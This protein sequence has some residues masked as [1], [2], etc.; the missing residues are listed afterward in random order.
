MASEAEIIIAFLFKRSGKSELSF[1]EMYLTLS[2]DMNWF[3]PDGAKDFIKDSVKN[4]LLIQKNDY[5]RPGFKADKINVPLGFRPAGELFKK[6]DK[7]RIVE[8]DVLE[9]VVNEI[10]EKAE[11]DK[12]EVLKKI[13][14]I[15]EEKNIMPEVAALIIGKEFEVFS[16]EVFKKIEKQILE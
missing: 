4:K 9:E 6:D 13:K 3:T 16:E 7:E 2:M 11:I 14:K 10:V 12:S 8:K 5:L 1:S 15:E